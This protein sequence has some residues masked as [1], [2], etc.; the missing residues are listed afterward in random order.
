MRQFG[1]WL[2]F[3][4]ATIRAP[5]FVAVITPAILG[6]LIAWQSEEIF[7][8]GYFLLVLLGVICVNA[9]INLV[10]DY[11]DRP[12][13]DINVEYIAPFTGGSRMIQQ[14]LLTPAQVL[15][16]GILFLAA[17]IAIGTY[18][19][20]ATWDS[21]PMILIL[22][23]IGVFTGFFYTAPPLKLGYRWFA[24]AWPGLNCGFLVT[25]GAYWV[26]AQSFSWLPV[27]ASIPLAIII[28]AVLWINEI[29]DY[30]ADKAIGKNNSVVSLGKEKAARGYLV[31]MVAA[32]LGIIFGV[33]FGG[34]T[35]LALLGLLSFPL[36]LRAMRIAI[37]NYAHSP[38][39]A[40]ANAMT[41]MIY[42]STGLLL[43]AGFLI[44]G[45]L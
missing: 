16:A 40:P 25:L 3:W 2:K 24:E 14:G 32:Y 6:T 29:P 12:T 45:V 41:P 34:V 28:A 27:I 21:G 37:R 23:A 11:Y 17:V 38:S 43:S 22:G 15:R 35:S 10:N 9:F 5:F 20:W 30:A 13:D 19:I 39:L 42:L 18:L 8:W 44:A 31:L 4:V 26:Q 33:A 1:D 36:A 7:R